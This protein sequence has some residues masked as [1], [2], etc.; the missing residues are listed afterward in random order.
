[1]KRLIFSGL[2]GLAACAS[3][4]E[5]CASRA[6]ADYN[7]LQAA[8]ATA[9]ANIARGFALEQ[10]VRADSRLTFCT[11]TRFGTRVSTGLS[12]CRETRLREVARPVPLDVEAEKKKLASMQALLPVA[13]EK[14]DRALAA[15][16]AG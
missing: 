14:R 16:Y 10:E 12:A 4:Q 7:G 8:I 15:C 11:G 13:R 6:S 3:P 9:E 1:M 5:Q 2:L